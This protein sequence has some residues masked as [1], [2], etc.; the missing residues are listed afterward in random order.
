MKYQEKIKGATVT[1]EGDD[2]NGYTVTLQDGRANNSAT[3]QDYA[4]ALRCF[5][6]TC[7]QASIIHNSLRPL[8]EKPNFAKTINL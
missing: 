6:G 8:P 2:K 4:R 1:L 7:E 3:F 5:D